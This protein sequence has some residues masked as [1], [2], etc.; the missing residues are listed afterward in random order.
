MIKAILWDIDGT[1][2]D[3]IKSQT[4][5]IRACFK[6]YGLGDCTD[7]MLDRYTQINQHYWEEL[8]LEKISKQQVLEY[9]FVDF[10]KEYNISSVSANEFNIAYESGLPDYINILGNSIDVISKLKGRIKQYAVTNGAFFVQEK[11]LEKSRL[12]D[13]LDG[14]FISDAVGYEKPSVKF[15]D[16]V[17][18]N[19]EHFN[20]DEI[21][22]VG[23]S[24]TSDMLGGNNAGIIC[25]WF[26]PNKNK[27]DTNVKIDYEI[28]NLNEVFD[29]IKE[30]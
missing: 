2:L 26:N 28:T 25:C 14:A 6:K 11:R 9:R 1:V 21:M 23:D 24:L 16:Y 8:E 20:R 5:S 12:N 7:E 22:I 19:I 17:F 29:I 10:F 30:R 15:F 27:N 13:L 18:Q 3:F 4:E